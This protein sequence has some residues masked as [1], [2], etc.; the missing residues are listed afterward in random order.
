MYREA[1]SK[2][3]LAGVSGM[4]IKT[5]SGI[6]RRS[7]L[8]NVIRDLPLEM[9]VYKTEMGFIPAARSRVSVLSSPADARDPWDEIA[10]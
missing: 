5:P 10:G 6:L 2:I 9:K 1:L 3:N 8:M 4:I 7:P